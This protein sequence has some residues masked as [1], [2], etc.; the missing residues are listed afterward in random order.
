MSPATILDSSLLAISIMM[1]LILA[2]AWF[3]FDR[4]RHA[5]TWAIG[6]A[7]LAALWAIELGVHFGGL[8]ERP[9]RIAV[10][11][12]GAMASAVNTIGFRQR[13]NRPPCF[14][15]FLPSAL[16]PA[17][18]A[19]ALN[20][21]APGIVVLAPL[22]LFD[23]V[24]LAIA[25]TTL[26]GRRKSERAAQHTAYAGLVTLALLSLGLFV[27]RAFA[28]A[29]ELAWTG[30]AILPLLPAAITGIGLF[31]I[32]LLAADLADQTRRLAATDMLSGLLNRRGFDG[33]V[34]ALLE[35]ARTNARRV[36][37]VLIDIDRFK[38]VNDS[39]GHQ[40]G[41]RVIARFAR[42]LAEQTGRRDLLARFGGEEFALLMVDADIAA[43]A[44]AAERLR[45]AIAA[46]DFDLPD[47]RR[48]TA[49]FGLAEMTPGAMELGD[50]LARADAALYQ[51]KAAGRDRVIVF[52]APPLSGTAA[53]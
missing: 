25:A 8:P 13:A 15:L 7:L 30:M 11:A 44:G 20:G 22:D 29:R 50:L 41:D 48:I 18:A 39:F 16:L 52:E 33:A 14:A 49:S 34:E 10:A 35:S 46:A 23:A 12:F 28:I 42:L 1:V 32:F 31:T 4:P 51:A 17:I 5:L 27:S 36:A 43:A 19:L 45:A 9:S 6:F 3:D 47:A 26:V 38:S 40:A 53:R 21:R 2:V 24:M 37:L